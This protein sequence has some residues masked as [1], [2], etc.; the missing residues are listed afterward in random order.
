MVERRLT[1]CHLY[2]QNM[3][4]YGDTGNVL[5]LEYRLRQRGITPV[6]IPCEVGEGLPKDVDIIVAGGGQDSGQLVVEKDL[7]KKKAELRSMV[8]DGVVVLTICGTYQLFGHRFVT[9][10]QGTIQGIGIFDLETHGSSER[11]IGNVIVD[12]EWG[13]LVGFENHSGKTRLAPE[14]PGLAKIIQG[15]GN[16]GESGEEGAIVFNT[17]GTYIHGPLLPKNPRFADELLTRALQRKFGAAD[18]GPLD[19][20]EEQKAHQVA[21][22]RPR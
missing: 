16:N 1:I 22:S 15:A 10:D 6:V 8:H 9:S 7:Q 5:T 3:N 14:Q 2:H 13:E 4:I 17:F 11:L 19:D 18:L 21:R 12:S 20:T